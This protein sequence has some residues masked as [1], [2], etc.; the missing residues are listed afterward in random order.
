[1]GSSG[2]LIVTKSPQNRPAEGSSGSWFVRLLPLAV[3]AALAVLVFAMGW[4]RALSLEALVRWR[5]ELDAFV[6]S[7]YPAALLGYV[8]LYIAV[9]ALSVPGGLLMTISGGVLFGW[10]AGG[11]AAVIGGTIGATL[12]FML[13]RYA[14]GDFVRRRLGPRLSALAEGFRED[15]FHYLLF[16][17]LV[18]VFPFSLVNLAPGLLGVR[19]STFVAATAIGV[20][21]ATFA[22]ATF[23]AGLDSVVAA[24][25]AAHRACLA[26][27]RSD[28]RLDF[29]LKAALTPQLFAAL[30]ALGLVALIPVAVRRWRSR[31]RG[32]SQSAL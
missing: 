17:R 31:R 7:H 14:L 29:S 15:A 20:I 30:S 22:F 18:P 10:L 26:A 13:V 16:L 9:V 2:A 1:V 25:E 32:A 6:Q 11:I 23:G 3:L 4:H 28:C 24:Q 12:L 8:G 5:S 27:A 19:L 21:P